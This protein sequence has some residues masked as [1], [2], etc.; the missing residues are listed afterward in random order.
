MYHSTREL[1]DQS[2]AHS[3]F[4]RRVYQQRELESATLL[5]AAVNHVLCPIHQAA[6]LVRTI[7][8][9]PSTTALTI[10]P[11]C[12]IEAAV[13][14][15]LASHAGLTLLL[16]LLL[17]ASEATESSA[18]LAALTWDTWVPSKP[19][20]LVLW[21]RQARLRGTHC[22]ICC[23]TRAA[24]LTKRWRWTTLRAIICLQ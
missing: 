5:S 10:T 18:I 7:L 13:A 16:L 1:P 12:L 24:G 4:L 19:G 8:L 15:I 14:C 9:S 21:W 6:F 22:T 20:V 23:G 3:L 2:A 11:I 17:V